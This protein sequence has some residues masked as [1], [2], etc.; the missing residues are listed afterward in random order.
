MPDSDPS[1]CREIFSGDRP[2]DDFL[3]VRPAEYRSI[4]LSHRG[5]ILGVG[6]IAVVAT[7]LWTIGH[8]PAAVTASHSVLDL[9]FAAVTGLGIGVAFAFRKE[10]HEDVIRSAR[11][12]AAS[13][14]NVPLLGSVPR[15]EF[16]PGGAAAADPASDPVGSRLDFVSYNDP[17]SPISEAYRSLRSSLQK[18][19]PGCSPRVILVTSSSPS[20]G[21]T[22]T[23]INV[24]IAL[25]ETGTATLLISTDFR[26]PRTDEVFDSRTCGGL[27]GVVSGSVRPDEAIV[28]TPVPNLSLLPCGRMPQRP[29]QVLVSD[30]FERLLADLR[31][32]YGYIVFDSPPIEK[33][34]EALVLAQTTDCAILVV[35]AGRSSKRLARKVLDRL[36]GCPT[37]VVLNAY[38]RRQVEYHAGS[39]S[40]GRAVS[41]S[42]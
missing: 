2:Y 17:K 8:D 20:E 23:A 33:V 34:P 24:A 30:A 36:R 21:K 39:S 14:G 10:R 25:A 15:V 6:A 28:S 13:L 5:T 1:P 9:G 19:A 22:T 12:V 7:L 31:K 41:G 32:H 42:L 35:R 18:F 29:E 4:L 37:A 11:D 40:A 3:K 16:A 26:R 38:G 27:S